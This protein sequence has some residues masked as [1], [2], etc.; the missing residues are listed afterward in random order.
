MTVHIRLVASICS[1]RYIRNNYLQAI[2]YQN[3]LE[4]PDDPDI[5]NL[6]GSEHSG[7]TSGSEHDF[8][9]GDVD[10]PS[11]ISQALAVAAANQYLT[12]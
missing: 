6:S 5:F 8:D 10:E 3:R 12:R 1:F 2:C 7:S 9:L 11:D 4:K